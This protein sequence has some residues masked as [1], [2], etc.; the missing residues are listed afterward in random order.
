MLV[1]RLGVVKLCD[2]GFARPYL[3]NETFTD[4]VATRWYRSPELLVGDPR[5]GKEVDIWAVGCLYAEMMTGE[6]LFPGESD[7]DQLF[8]IVRV[9]GKLNARHQVLILRN[10][11]FKGMKQ[12]QNTSLTQI[13]PE[14]N[15]DCL[16]FLSDCLKMDGII[17]PDTAVLLKHVLFTHD[18]FLDNFTAELRAKL[19]QEMRVNPLLSRIPSYGSERNTSDEKQRSMTKTVMNMMPTTTAELKVAAVNGGSKGRSNQINLTLLSSLQ[20]IKFNQQSNTT[21]DLGL[22]VNSSNNNIHSHENAMIIKNTP[23]TN[24]NSNKG[25]K[26]NNYSKNIINESDH[27]HIASD[28]NFSKTPSLRL[29]VNSNN[30]NP[31]SRTKPVPMN[32]LVSKENAKFTRVLSA[33]SSKSNA[34]ALERN[35]NQHHHNVP[36]SI[37]SSNI[38][39]M[40]ILPSS[41]IQFQSLQIESFNSLNNGANNDPTQTKR[42]SP[43]NGPFSNGV[44]PQYF[45]NHRRSSNISELQQMVGAQKS[46]AIHAQNMLYAQHIQVP[47]SS[48]S[49]KRERDRD[50]HQNSLDVSL[51]PIGFNNNGRLNGS[52][53]ELSSIVN[54]GPNAA[55]STNNG[56]SNSSGSGMHKISIT[57]HHLTKEPSPRILPPP[58][59]WLSGNLMST[60]GKAVQITNNNGMRRMTDWK[61]IGNSGNHSNNNNKRSYA[62]PQKF[63]GNESI[64]SSGN[65]LILPNC[66]GAKTSPQKLSNAKKK[67]TPI[68]VLS[69]GIHVFNT[70]VRSY[71]LTVHYQI[72]Q[73]YIS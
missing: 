6:P 48:T 57:S 23:A 56:K 61:T 22:N 62:P 8:Q 45:T 15:G 4:Y 38:I 2:F 34:D 1:S 3:E 47:A 27:I 12:E 28:S 37:A 32:N 21:N 11:M 50:G 43:V 51:V 73:I 69:D 35:G 52:S 41:P 10:T 58:P 30:S 46:K 7:I 13:F 39:D 44:A 65:D 42:L 31:P 20:S 68:S 33:K 54:I 60:Q 19:T 63:H 71:Y 67:L 59:P 9:L 64:T 26:N 29:Y 5:Y 53:A 16:E 36:N 17:R 55:G 14:W 70:P 66:P 24:M 49:S 40:Q 25:N 72:N 18:N